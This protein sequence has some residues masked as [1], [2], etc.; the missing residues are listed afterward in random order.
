MPLKFA[1]PQSNCSRLGESWVDKL[2]DAYLALG[3]DKRCLPN[4]VDRLTE[5]ARQHWQTPTA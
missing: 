4:I 2:A 5:E 1:L 3:E